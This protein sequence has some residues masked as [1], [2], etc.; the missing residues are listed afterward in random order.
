MKNDVGWELWRSFLA[1][2]REGNLSRAARQ[3]GLTQPT[4]GRHIDELER[5]LGLSLFTRSP[6]GLAPTDA[7]LELRP[8]AQAM[9]GAAD[10]LLRAASGGASGTRGVV[11]VTTSEIF[12]VEI[13]PKIFA[14]FRARYPQVAIEL[15]VT[16]VTQ[17][18][19]E[20]EADIA[21]RL[22]RPTQGALVARQV[23]KIRF[24]LFAHRDY[25]RR[26]GTPQTMEQLLDHTLIGFDKG[27]ALPALPALPPFL[28]DIPSPLTRDSFAFRSDSALA[29]VAMVRAGYGI[30]RGG[31]IAAQFYPD[32]VPV[33]AG[34]YGAELDLWVAMHEDARNSRRVRLVFDHLV[35]SLTALC[36]KSR[37][38]AARKAARS[39]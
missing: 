36:A 34:K 15:S 25:L 24:G 33:L 19:L 16:N 7:G 4:V 17:N 14:A 8:H 28:R 39:R 38:I 22:P 35:K 2:L 23:G 20:R 10:A 18:L 32:I 9:A 26:H 12:A 30:G 6:R 31:D 21:V 1:V 3:L 5:A 37:R 29:Q 13:L 11:R 27:A